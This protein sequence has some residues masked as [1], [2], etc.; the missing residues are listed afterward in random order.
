MEISTNEWLALR[1]KIESLEAK[2][3]VLEAQIPG[4]GTA[5]DYFG[6]SAPSGWVLCSGRTIGA[7]A[8]G[9]TER[10]NAD[11]ESLYSLL[12]SS[13]TNVELP[14]QDDAGSPTV[15][16]ISAAADFAA[17]KRM[18]LPDYRDRS[19]IGRGNMGG[20]AANRVTSA[21]SGIDTTKVAAGGG[22]QTETIAQSDLPD[23]TLTISGT[24]NNTG[25]HTHNSADLLRRIEGSA[26]GG[27]SGTVANGIFTVDPVTTTSAG[28]HQHTV[29]GSTSSINGGVAQTNLVVVQP[30]VVC[31]KIIKL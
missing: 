15:R 14:I 10:A 31:N 19:S 17:N 21:V 9:A 16:G 4:T 28:A 1:R 20:T 26:G 25:N 2:V 23:T 5:L 12:W 30:S 24:T 3:P 29:S 22:T 6:S 18:P 11:T 27:T 7:A 8:S 13:T